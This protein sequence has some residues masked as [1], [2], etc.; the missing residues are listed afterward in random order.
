MP[1]ASKEASVKK[2]SGFYTLG[3]EIANAITHGLGALFAVA[4]MVFCIV[5]SALDGDGLSIFAAVLYGL[6]LVVLYSMSTLYHAITHKK[7]KNVLRI[8]DHC[9]IF[10]LIAGTYSPYLLI[11]LRGPLG[12]GLFAAIW[13]VAVLGIV[14]NTVDLRRFE[15]LSVVLYLAMGW[16]AMA[17][18]KPL[19]QALPST[20]FWLMVG[21]GIVYTMG[22][23]FYAGKWKYAHSVWH[24]F[25]LGASVMHFLSIILYVIP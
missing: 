22:M 12:Y 25:V 1:I 18:I 23:I 19:Y 13:G 2:K 24:L 3:E 11:T 5:L 15:K 8:C 4:A 21:G 9:G 20:G 16:A 14:L 17:A 7:A 6:S 10:F